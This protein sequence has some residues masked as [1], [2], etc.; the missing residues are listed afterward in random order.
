MIIN[1]KIIGLFIMFCLVLG[2]VISIVVV[3]YAPHMDS[4]S[5]LAST[6]ING[7]SS[8]KASYSYFDGKKSHN[9]KLNKG[10]ILNLNYE[11][12]VKEGELNITLQDPDGVVVKNFEANTK[13]TDK[14]QAEKVGEYKII[15]K[16]T[17]TKGNFHISW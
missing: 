13:G 15:V 8:M 17:K 4:Y 16:G 1:K 6:E 11:S 7:S 2:A 9:I 10:E 5:M 14:I 12:E 3:K